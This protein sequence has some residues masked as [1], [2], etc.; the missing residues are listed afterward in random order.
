MSTP[1]ILPG[2]G[3]RRAPAGRVARGRAPAQYT[4]RLP[5]RGAAAVAEWLRKL[6]G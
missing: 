6:G 5:A 4:D 1:E 2:R 3:L